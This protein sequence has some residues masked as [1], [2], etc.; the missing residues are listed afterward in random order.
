MSADCSS[1][2]VVEVRNEG[3]KLMKP[4]LT[5]LKKN[6]SNIWLSGLGILN[7]D[8]ELEYKCVI[9]AYFLYA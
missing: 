5:S 8:G 4:L 2:S 9:L 3:K 7:M 1:S 6:S